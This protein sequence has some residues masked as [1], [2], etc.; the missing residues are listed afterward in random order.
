MEQFSFGD[1]V[2]QNIQPT[3]KEACI[4]NTSQ[5]HM[6]VVKIQQTWINQFCLVFLMSSKYCL[7]MFSIHHH[8]A[9]YCLS[10]FPF[11]MILTEN[12]EIYLFPC[13]AKFKAN[14]FAKKNHS[15]STMKQTSRSSISTFWIL[16]L[17]QPCSNKP[18]YLWNNTNNTQWVDHLESAYR[19]TLSPALAESGARLDIWA[20]NRVSQAQSSNWMKLLHR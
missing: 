14:S 4:C 6:T 2:P 1:F 17:F 13:L 15:N 5:P 20:L 3:Y 7:I 10:C 8:N 19:Q 18:S 16:D 12:G 9:R 11:P